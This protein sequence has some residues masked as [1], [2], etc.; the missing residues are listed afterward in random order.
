MKLPDGKRENQ[1]D[2]EFGGNFLRYIKSTSHEI[3]S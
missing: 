3:K 1:D 2:L